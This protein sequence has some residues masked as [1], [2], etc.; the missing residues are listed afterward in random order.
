MMAPKDQKGEA[1][2]PLL[3]K[4]VDKRGFKTV[5]NPPQNS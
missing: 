5:G 2:S 3:L 4:C 1:G